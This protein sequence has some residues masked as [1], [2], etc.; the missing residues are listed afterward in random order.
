MACLTYNNAFFPPVYMK[1]S[2]FNVFFHCDG[3]Q[4]LRSLSKAY[5]RLQQSELFERE[6]SRVML[7]FT[8]C[9]YPLQ[10]NK[11]SLLGGNTKRELWPKNFGGFT[12][13]L[14]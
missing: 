8:I 9:C 3:G 10:L 11:E 12:L 6:S 4:I 2:L 5:M 7:S 13:L 1:K 14:F